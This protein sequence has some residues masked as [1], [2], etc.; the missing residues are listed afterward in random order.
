MSIIR[1][2][3][4][5]V[6]FC[7]FLQLALAS[8]AAADSYHVEFLPGRSDDDGAMRR[9][10]VTAIITPK[11][12]R[13]GLM[14]S[15]T[16]T[17]LYHQWA[18]FVESIEA[19]R[20]DGTPVELIYEP[21][22]QWRVSGWRR[23][24]VTV[25]YTMSL[26]HDR[27]M[28]D[29]GDDELASATAYG[30]MWTGR[31]LFMEGAPSDNITVTFNGP[32]NWRVTS[33]WKT[34]DNTGLA[35]KSADT[36]D[37]LDSAFFAG[38][39]DETIVTIGSI[40]ARLATGPEMTAERDL[41][42]QTLETYLPIYASLFDSAAVE[43]PVI[44]GIRGSFW[45]GGVMGRSISLTHGGDLIPQTIPMVI[46]IVSHEAFHLWNAQWQYNERK[47]SEIEWMAEGIAEYYT[48]LSSIRSNNIPTDY[49]LTELGNRWATYRNALSHR[50]IS[51]A[52]ASK[53]KDSQSYDLVYSGGM[54]ATWALDMFIRKQT[55][56]EKSFDD[57]LKAMQAE[58]TGVSAKDLTKLSFI[59]TVKSS[60]GVDVTSFIREHLS[61]SHPMPMNDLLDGVGLCLTENETD[62]GWSATLGNC[63]DLTDTVYARQT[64]WMAMQ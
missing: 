51:A 55:N 9:A 48:W 12:G 11:H 42:K 56:H 28:N 59:Q 64:E 41:Y 38:T 63:G 7:M 29:P 54:M 45:G 60:T 19:E 37:L 26:Q 4:V 34:T 30:V 13:I 39:H 20:S 33:P 47:R 5:T 3:A 57:V 25:R 16:D 32:E 10:K 35:F 8:P 18:T 31:A 40:E 44:V 2:I 27:F 17:G 62:D 15:G 23:G 58:Y 22:G 36:D 50:S 46:Y 53:L 21:H 43:A 52:G 6:S 14:R 49:F 1:S 61:Q 24:E